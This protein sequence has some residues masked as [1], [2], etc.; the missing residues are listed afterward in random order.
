MYCHDQSVL[1]LSLYISRFVEGLIHQ[2]VLVCSLVFLGRILLSSHLRNWVRTAP[3]PELK[4]HWLGLWSRI[5]LSWGNY[6]NHQAASHI[7][8][9]YAHQK[10]KQKGEISWGIATCITINCDQLIWCIS[11]IES[12]YLLQ[13]YVSHHHHQ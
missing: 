10:N 5:S 9:S 1:S 13:I 12:S 8:P 3:Q 6:S 2:G 7:A 11:I 4:E